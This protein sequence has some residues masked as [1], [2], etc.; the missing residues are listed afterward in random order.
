MENSFESQLLETVK[1]IIKNAGLDDEGLILSETSPYQDIRYGYQFH[2]HFL[3]F[4][5]TGNLKYWLVDMNYQDFSKK[6]H[7]DAEYKPASSNEGRKTRLF[8]K[9]ADILYDFADYIIEEFK[10]VKETYNFGVELERERLAKRLKNSNSSKKRPKKGDS[11]VKDITDYTIIDL[12]TT[13]KYPDRAEIIEMAAIRVRSGK[14]VAQYSQLVK[15]SNPISE[16]VTQITGI[17]NEMVQH[18]PSIGIVLKNFINFVGDDIILGHNIVSYDSTILYDLCEYY[19]LRE[20]SNTMLDTLRYA[21]YC[22][23][24]I[25]DYKL[26]TIAKYFGIEYQAH[27]SLNDCTANFYVY[28]YLKKHFK[29][30]YIFSQSKEPKEKTAI[31]EV[32]P[33]YAELTDKKI[34]LTGEFS[35]GSRKEIKTFLEKQG[36]KISTGVSG[37]TDYLI[38][39][40]LGSPDWKY[41]NYGDKVAK[42]QELQKSGRNIAIIQ[43][44]EFFELEMKAGVLNG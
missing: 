41:G 12:E 30:F 31:A 34:V 38:I 36:A 9:N 18:S 3:R 16:V 43:E 32:K 44:S 15:P 26:T 29:G 4:K 8:L 10:V 5:T 39:G 27:R 28:E 11:I 14:I 17:T 21:H 25:E 42:A 2:Y 33:Q 19:G 1:Q 7:T 35:S 37:K 20:F 6:F 23:I 40:A 13:S 22:D 24:E